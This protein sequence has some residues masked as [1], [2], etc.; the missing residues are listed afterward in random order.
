MTS[1]FLGPVD[2]FEED[3]PEELCPPGD[4]K[5]GLLYGTSA[6]SDPCACLWSLLMSSLCSIEP[7]RSWACLCR[8]RDILVC[9]SRELFFSSRQET[10][11]LSRE[12]AVLSAEPPMPIPLCPEP[13]CSRDPWHGGGSG[14]GGKSSAMPSLR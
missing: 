8:S 14:G 7:T 3:V 10:C 6:S 5:L 11:C 12:L 9:C 2:P 4:G 1:P 13:E